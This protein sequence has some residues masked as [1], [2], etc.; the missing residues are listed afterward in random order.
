[1]TKQW[2]RKNIIQQNEVTK[3]SKKISISEILA[4]VL[5]NRGIISEDRAIRFLYPALKDMPSPFLINGMEKAVERI[6]IA[7]KR[8][9]KIMLYG[10]YDA[11]GIS[12][13]SLTY[14]YLK[15]IGA[16]VSTHIP[17]RLKEG[18]GL[19]IEAVKEFRVNGYTLIITLDCGISNNEAIGFAKANNIDTIIAD[20]HEIPDSLPPAYAILD[21]KNDDVDDFKMLAGVGVAFNLI[22]ALR[23][24][25]KHEGF[26]S[27]MWMPN[28]KDYMD[29]AALGTIADMVPFTG[30]NRII[31][32]IGTKVFNNSTRLGIQALKDV[33][34]LSGDTVST[35]H[36][37]F[38][39]APRINAAGRLDDP[40][41]GVELL[42]TDNPELA[43][44]LAKMLDK[45]NTERHSIEQKIL[46]NT[47]EL[48]NLDPSNM[49]SRG[50]VLASEEWHPGVIGVV[51]SKLVELY[52][53]PTIL[54]S[55]NNDIGKGSAR[56]IE[57]IHMYETL[58]SLSNYLVSFG[59]H[60]FAAGLVIKHDMFD[61]FKAN[62]I[63]LLDSTLTDEMLTPV[64][65]IDQVLKFKD[66]TKNII[67]ELELLMPFGPGNSEPIFVSNN[68]KISDPR[69]MRNNTIKFK[70]IQDD[71]SFDVIF[72]G[73]KEHIDNLP[74]HANIAYT[75]RNNVFDGYD[76]IILNLKDM[77]EVQN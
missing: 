39:I 17:H 38:R 37:S 77:R 25:M 34:S 11:D 4:A 43:K 76:S 12:A 29:L 13:T 49:D 3:L 65:Y 28:L 22:M 64:I 60:K 54:I 46:R 70:A 69:V 44:K 59:G 51:A 27:D 19:N 63:Q 72:Y 1:M 55:L 30:E 58:K 35:S 9:E 48:I 71:T 53:K 15:S 24:V 47:I 36:V 42:T 73:S 21:P 75:L 7:I 45:M 16:I 31:V 62:F 2:K 56:S 32:S 61:M 41:L 52:Y 20:H 66:I 68:I 8:R 6:I 18:Y 67:K 5:I 74:R 40:N 26:F 23:N 14:L 57:S 50:I 33:S 10:D